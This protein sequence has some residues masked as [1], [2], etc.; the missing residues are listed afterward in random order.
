MS[1]FAVRPSPWAEDRAIWQVYIE[2]VLDQAR[3]S[4]L[5]IA[6]GRIDYETY[7]LLHLRRH[8]WE[9]GFTYSAHEGERPVGYTRCI[10]RDGL[11][12]LTEFYTHPRVQ[13]QGAGRALIE[14]ALS[15]AEPG[16]QRLVVASPDQAATARYLQAGMSARTPVYQLESSQ[17]L[18]PPDLG[19]LQVR[20]A[21]LYDLSALDDLDFGALG[22]RRPEEHRYW[23]GAGRPCTLF[24][25]AGR[26]V[27]YIYVGPRAGCGP[28]VA[29]AEDDSATIALYAA[30]AGATRQDAAI[31]PGQSQRR[32]LA[33]PG[34]N[35]T[36]LVA[37]L[38][39]GMRL[40][41]YSNTLFSQRPL[42]GLSR[43]V[44]FGPYLF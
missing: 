30:A 26:P 7:P 44:S 20:Q 3:R 34:E 42:P 6:P 2:S 24:T 17:P 35:R 16:T 29:L 22:Y 39:G 27:A 38:Q 18:P 14:A 23:L 15:H 28:G 10:R 5:A 9:S 12:E 1:S 36:A 32:V 11:W 13:G 37:L 33:V 4:G 19:D 25:R 43:Y 31:L 40:G 21:T 8:L 41:G